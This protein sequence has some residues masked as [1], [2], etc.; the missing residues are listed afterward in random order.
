M[1]HSVSLTPE[2]R[3]DRSVSAG[4]GKSN[5]SVSKHLEAQLEQNQ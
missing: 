2:M 1:K 4:R 3:A 5:F